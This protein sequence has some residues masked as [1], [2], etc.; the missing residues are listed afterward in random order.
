MSQRLLS[1]GR[2]PM[3][4]PLAVLAVLESMAYGLVTRHAYDEQLPIAAPLTFVFFLLLPMAEGYRSVAS[5]EAKVGT[6]SRASVT[7]ML[8]TGA[9]FGDV[10]GMIGVL[11]LTPFSLLVALIGGIP[12]SLGLAIQRRRMR[13]RARS[14]D[15][16]PAQHH[17]RESGSNP[18]V[19]GPVFPNLILEISR[20]D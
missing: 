14:M 8:L 3:P 2:L 20:C 5:G 12:A 6:L 13:R 16:F 9:A 1:I 19:P 10:L 4:R 7:L 18:P 17:R 15:S 11:V